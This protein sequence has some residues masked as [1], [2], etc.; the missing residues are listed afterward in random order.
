MS[1][2]NDGLDIGDRMKRY[3]SVTEFMLPRRI[4]V[5]LRVDGRAFHTITRKR[6]G[7]AW[8]ME[9]VEQMS[10]TALT[11]L[12]DMQGCDFCYCQS[13]EISF[14]I[15]DYR[16]IRTD[17]WFSYDLRKIISIS[18]SLASSVFSR[19]YG[20]T[21]CF[22][23]RAFSIP[24]DEVA[25]YFIWRQIDATRNAIQMAGR[26]HFS[27]RQLHKKSCNEIQELLFQ[28]KGINFN[29]YPA[30]RKRGFCIIDGVFDRK[31]PIFTKN[32]FYI[33]RFVDIRKD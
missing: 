14:L 29:D 12:S 3:E 19:E 17:A 2:K 11:M 5:I 15:T 1:K 23:S 32:R 8:L 4:P 26:E 28:E 16:T 22:D 10:D 7:R 24:Q 27:A 18:S 13:D 30:I 21:V 25:N 20:R 6:F 9:F 31:I 33:E